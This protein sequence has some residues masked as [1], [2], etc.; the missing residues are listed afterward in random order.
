[1]AEKRYS[2]MILPKKMTQLKVFESSN[3]KMSA[4]RDI[5]LAVGVTINF[6][7]SDDKEFILE[8]DSEKMKQ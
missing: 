5:C 7:S 6:K 3:N 1:L 2:Y 8:N 4:L